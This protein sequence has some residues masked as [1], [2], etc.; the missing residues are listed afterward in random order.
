MAG[1]NQILMK[2]EDQSGLARGTLSDANTEARTATE[3]T[4]LRN[5]TYTTIADNQQ[6]LERALSEGGRAMDKYADL[7]NLAPAG[8]YE[9]S[10]DWDDSVI[11]DTETQL[12]QRLLKAKEMLTGTDIN[13]SDIAYALK[14]VNTGQFSTFFKHKE[15]VTPSDF[16]KRNSWK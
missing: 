4:I 5:R 8:E 13:I 7:Y 12:Q 2:I 1:L 15:G 10:F 9:V 3:L 11:A 6:A 16:R 14:F